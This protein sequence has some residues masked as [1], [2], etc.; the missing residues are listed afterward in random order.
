MTLL[1]SQYGLSLRFIDG[2]DGREMRPDLSDDLQGKWGVAAAHAAVWQAVVDDGSDTALIFED[3]V[4]FDIRLKQQLNALRGE[5]D[6]D[7]L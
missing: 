1:A 6:D 2:V 4:D 5:I 3:D 7:Y